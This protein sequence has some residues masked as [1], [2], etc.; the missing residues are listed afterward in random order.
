MTIITIQL[1][2]GVINTYDEIYNNKYKDNLNLHLKLFDDFIDNFKLVLNDK[3]LMIDDKIIFD[4]IVTIT[5]VKL[6]T[7]FLTI[8]DLG[9]N[10]LLKINIDRIKNFYHIIPTFRIK[11]IFNIMESFINE[12]HC[13]LSYPEL[14]IYSYINIDN[15]ITK[16]YCDRSIKYLLY[17]D[18]D[19]ILDCNY[20]ILIIEL[21]SP[22]YFGGY[23]LTEY[24]PNNIINNY[25]IVKCCKHKYECKGL[26]TN[27][28]IEVNNF[29]ET[30]YIFIINNDINNSI[31]Y[32]MYINYLYFINS[33]DKFI[34]YKNYLD[35]EINK[36][37]DTLKKITI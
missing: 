4:E 28:Y 3:I 13:I 10:E 22:K 15:S 7:N 36:G 26:V 19:N 33:Y 12:E 2:S 32:F 17:D 27:F 14:Y 1:L 34:E 18:F 8:Y 23:N 6:P 35:N 37:Y 16:N 29:G 20:S 21:L 5:L 31:K 11:D 30:I 24:S 9:L 25:L